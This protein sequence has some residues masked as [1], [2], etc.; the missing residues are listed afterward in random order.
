MME[1]VEHELKKLV[2]K[3]VVFKIDNKILK[4]G[5]IQIFNT[6]QF[7][8]KF[9]LFNNNLE[10]DYELPY[11]YSIKSIKNGVVFDYCLSAFCPFKDEMYYKLLLCDKSNSSKIH[12]RYLMI[13]VQDD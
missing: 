13:S 6:K 12:N 7:F 3:N 1:N 4:T 2:L 5:K 9:K 11:P 10:K 8:I